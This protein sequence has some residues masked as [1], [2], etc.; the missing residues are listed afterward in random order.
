MSKRHFHTLLSRYRKGECSEQEKRIV[1]QWFTLLDGEK[2]HHTYEES[3]Q[4]ENRI[5]QAIQHKQASVS[6]TKVRKLPVLFPWRWVAAAAVLLAIVWGA[7]QFQLNNT[8]QTETGLLESQRSNGLL[9]RTNNTADLQLIKLE[10]GSEISLSPKGSI[11][12]PAQFEGNKR[13]VFLTG[14]AFFKV[15][16]NPQKPFLVYTG[17]VVTKVLGTSFWVNVSDNDQAVEVSVV[18]GKVSVFQRDARNDYVTEKVKS[19]VILTPNQRVTY[20]QKSQAFVTS[21]VEQPV[22]VNSTEQLTMTEVPFVFDDVPLSEV[23]AKLEAAYGIEIIL[24]NE[25]L[26]NCLFTADIT[27]QPLFTKLD[28]L[29]ASLNASYEVRGTKILVSGTGCSSN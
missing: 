16:R 23:V 7:Y 3:Q 17:D 8:L 5:W 26:K 21:L 24:E 14:K 18:T 11:E 28:L 25:R 29:C 15:A 1:E 6:G 2:P 12:F 9:K 13:E 4:I 20:E 27:K 19:G 22:L 10:D